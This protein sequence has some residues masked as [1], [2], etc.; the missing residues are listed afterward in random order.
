MRRRRLISARSA[1]GSFRKNSGTSTIS[2]P[3]AAAD[4]RRQVLH[5]ICHR[6]IHAQ[7]QRSGAG[8]VLHDRRGPACLTPPSRP[9]SPGCGRNRRGFTMARGGATVGG[10][11]AGLVRAAEPTRPCLPACPYPCPPACPRHRASRRKVGHS[12]WE[13]RRGTASGLLGLSRN[14]GL[15]SGASLMGAGLP[16]MAPAQRI[17]FMRRRQRFQPACELT[18]LLAGALMI[19]AMAV[20]FAGALRTDIGQGTIVRNCLGRRYHRPRPPLLKLAESARRA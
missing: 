3:R 6:Q 13:G 20:V 19:G 4:G 17:S 10:S 14:I 11:E 18:F 12:I 9:L 15:I 1:A 2:Y 16:P 5:R 7:V 8:T